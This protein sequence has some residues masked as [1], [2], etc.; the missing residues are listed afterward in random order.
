MM[1]WSTDVTEHAHVTEVKNPA[2]AGNNQNHYSQIACHLDRVN[3]C[4]QFDLATRIATML[5]LEHQPDGNGNGSNDN[6]NDENKEEHEPDE[7]TWNLSLYSSLTRKVTDYF[8]IAHV[9]AN[10]TSPVVPLPLRTF[11][12][13][14]TAT[15]LA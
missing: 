9:L 7:K 11:A 14:T 5:R 4:F 6:D 8:Q 13:S 12:S 10:N 2:H 3:K 15:H 1:Q